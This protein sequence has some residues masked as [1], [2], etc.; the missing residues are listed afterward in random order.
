MLKGGSFFKAMGRFLVSLRIFI[1]QKLSID[2]LLGFD[3]GDVSIL[4]GIF[5][6]FLLSALTA[7][8]DDCEKP[9]VP[10][11]SRPPV[12]DQVAEFSCGPAC[13]V[14]L[15]FHLTGKWLDERE[16]MRKF[17]S[18]PVR[19]GTSPENLL[20]GLE[21]LGFNARRLGEM[22]VENLFEGLMA[23]RYY[24]LLVRSGNEPHWVLAVGVE[25][26]RVVIM[27]PWIEE[28]NYR[29]LD[30]AD[31]VRMWTASFLG[32]TVVRLALEIDSADENIAFNLK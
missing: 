23:D 17:R 15:A 18:S 4:T 27:D 28:M 3:I 29:H 13:V 14:S 26:E 10:F 30:R 8:A 1:A 20:N 16:L 19:G 11:A 22:D 2:Y 7:Q 6:T 21:Q 31:L 12:V 25:G 9:L 32:K 24:I 5:L